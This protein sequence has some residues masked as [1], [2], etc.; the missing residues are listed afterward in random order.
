MGVQNVYQDIEE[1]FADG[2]NDREAY[3][4]RWI[5]VLVQ[6]NCEKKTATKLGKAGYETYIPTQQEVHQWSDRKK[7]VDRLIMPMVVFVRANVLEEEWLRGQSYIF[8]LL[9][10]PGTVEDK[11]KFATPIPDYQIERLKFLLENAEDEVTLV[12]NLKVGDI[13]RVISGPLKGLEGVVSTADEKSSI[14]G[15]MID[16]LGYACVKIAKNYLTC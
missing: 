7:K 15:V 2:T 4:K 1:S 14:V 10:L 16:G 13:V 5:A 8:K 9:A 12:S 11:K 3:P 6:V